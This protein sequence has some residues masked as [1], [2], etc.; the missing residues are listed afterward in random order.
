MN[1]SMNEITELSKEREKE[2]QTTVRDAW[3]GS[4]SRDF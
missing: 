4:I 1:E 2:N 3:R